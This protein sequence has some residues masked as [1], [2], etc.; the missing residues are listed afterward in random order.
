MS[1]KSHIFLLK[2]SQSVFFSK[3]VFKWISKSFI[4]LVTKFCEVEV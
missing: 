1:L 3:E 2:V 4:Q